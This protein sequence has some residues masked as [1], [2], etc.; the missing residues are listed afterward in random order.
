M[1][2]RLLAGHRLFSSILGGLS[3]LDESFLF[4]S[5]FQR[6]LRNSLRS[7]NLEILCN[8]LF[9]HGS[10]LFGDFHL[11]HFFSGG[12]LKTLPTSAAVSS[13]SVVGASD[14]VGSSAN[15]SATMASSST[16]SAAV[17]ASRC[18]FSAVAS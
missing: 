8:G 9:N 14:E 1:L 10:L 3:R 17:A 2:D 16:G 15:S 13:M 6:V 4:G 5:P 11:N 12:G 18:G 7:S